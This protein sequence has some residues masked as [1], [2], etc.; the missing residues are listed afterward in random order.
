MALTINDNYCT[1][2]SYRFKTCVFVLYKLSVNDEG[3]C[4]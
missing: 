4:I 1:I 2:I 3:F